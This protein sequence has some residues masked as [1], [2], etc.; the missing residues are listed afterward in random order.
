MAPAIGMV[1]NLAALPEWHIVRFLREKIQTR[2]DGMR[3][4]QASAT[5]TGTV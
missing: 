4:H 3:H 1:R 2:G 5:V